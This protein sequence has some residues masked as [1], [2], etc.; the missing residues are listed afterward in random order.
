MLKNKKKWVS[1]G[2]GLQYREH[3]TRKHGVRFDRYYRGRYTVA[4]KTVT[5]G[6]GWESQGWTKIKS[7]EKLCEF[8]RNAQKGIKPR[9][10]KEER[11]LQEQRRRE[12]E[13]KAQIER[14]R[15][16]TLDEVAQRYIEWAIENKKSYYDDIN[17]YQNHIKPRLGEKRLSELSPFD[18]ERV[19]SQLLKKGLS[20][21]TVKHCLV[22]VRQIINKA[23]AWG[24]WRGEN[25]V[26]K[27]KLPR[28]NNQRIRFLSYEEAD[29]LLEHLQKVSPQLHNMALLS[30]HTGMR[31]GEIFNLKWQHID[32]KNRIIYVADPKSGRSRITHM[33]NT[34]KS[35]FAKMQKG[36]PEELVFKNRKGGKITEISN[37][38]SRAVKQ[39]GF[40]D[41]ITD[42]RQRVTF[43][44]LRHTFASWLAIEGTP[45]LTIKELLG[46]K[47]L[48]MTERYSH[49]IPDAKKEA[50]SII[51]KRMRKGKSITV[52]HSQNDG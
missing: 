24:L 40:N 7:L 42:T 17:R 6:F 46:H 33:T 14:Q 5:I 11:E 49:L 23:I 3:P 9:N 4:G 52:L 26:S 31:A 28:L 41:G 50:I 35:M 19:K 37:S 27:I 8:R 10:L 44:T 13:L 32:F 36:D 18:L 22:L 15:N 16:I 29:L 25:P 1:I 34:V 21:A 43:H 38:F 47:T 39:L 2:N 45:I 20:P 12:E 30:L 48:A 51:D